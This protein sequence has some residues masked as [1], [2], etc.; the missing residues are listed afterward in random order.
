MTAPNQFDS[1][2]DSGTH[3][4][5]PTGSKRD[6]R[7]G[8]GRYDLITPI[9]LKRL[10]V[11][12]ENGAKKYGDH[13]WE[14]GQPVS[15]YL[16]S[17]ARHLYQ[18]LAGQ[19]EEDHLAA[20]AWNAFAAIHTIEM[21]RRGTLSAELDDVPM[22]HDFILPTVQRQ[23]V[24]KLPIAQPHPKFCPNC[25]TKDCTCKCEEE[26]LRKYGQFKLEHPPA[27]GQP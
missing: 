3:E 13:N 18:Y 7:E 24:A 14:K 6:T 15:R 4:E 25:G 23:E 1:V 21:V 9:G 20:V 19:R 10:A 17:A 26:A 22:A 5:F 12:Y 8:K 11:H 16:D 2:K 27:D